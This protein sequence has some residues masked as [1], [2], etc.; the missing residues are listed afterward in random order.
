VFASSDRFIGVHFQGEEMSPRQRIVSV[1]YAYVANFAKTIDADGVVIPD[2]NADMVDGHSAGHDIG[3]IPISDGVVNQNLNAD[4]V[5]GYQAGHSS[6]QIPVSDGAANNNLNADMVDGYHAGH[7]SGQIPVSDGLVN[8][9]LNAD[10]V[11]GYSAQDIIALSARPPDIYDYRTSTSSGTPKELGNIKICYGETTIGGQSSMTITDL[12]FSSP[13]SYKVMLTVNVSF[14]DSRVPRV[15]RI[16]NS[17]FTIHNDN[18]V[19]TSVQ[20]FAIGN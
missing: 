6:G 12:P 14:S 7:G 9:N 10:T 1:P 15:I 4:K 18:S 17:Q 8:T 2:L 5:D 20:W 3:N 16:S 13:G 11:D 19:S